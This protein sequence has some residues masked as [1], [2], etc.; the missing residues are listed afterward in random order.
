MNDIEN[1]PCPKG[2]EDVKSSHYWVRTESTGSGLRYKW[3]I[4]L[5][6]EFLMMSLLE[7]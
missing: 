6:D 3:I 2:Y 4:K 7:D 1:F 5:P